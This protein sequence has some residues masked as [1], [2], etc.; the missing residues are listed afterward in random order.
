MMLHCWKDRL[1][2]ITETYGY[3][4][5][6]WC[7]YVGRDECGETCMLENGHEGPHEWTPDDCIRIT[8]RAKEDG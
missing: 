1:E 6:Q 7:D 8:F 2:W 5:D 3:L 4:S